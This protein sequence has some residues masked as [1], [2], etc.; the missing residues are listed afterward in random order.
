MFLIAIFI[1]VLSWAYWK[2]FF[3]FPLIFGMWWILDVMFF[4]DDMFMYEPNYEFWREDNDTEWWRNMVDELGPLT[5]VSYRKE[6][7]QVRPRYI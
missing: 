2:F 3:M 7:I 5:Q 6:V 4:E 1:T